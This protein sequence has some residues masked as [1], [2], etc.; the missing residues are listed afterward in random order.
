MSAEEHANLLAALS[1]DLADA[2]ERA[3]QSVVG[4]DARRRVPG[5]GIVWPEGGIVV[6]ADHVIERHDEISLVTSGGHRIGATLIG[7]DPGSDV[8]VL[9]PASAAGRPAELAPAESARV[10]SLALA[11]GRTA[12]GATS[13][14]FGIISAVGGSWRSMRGGAIDSYLRADLTLYPGYSGGPIVDASGRVMGMNSSH[15]AGGQSVALPTAVV[16]GIVDALVAHGRI[17]RAYLGVTS[18]PI[19]VPEA[20]REKAHVD[21]Q[22]GLLLLSVEPGSPADRGGLF[23][24]DVLLAVNDRPVTHPEALQAALGADLV[25]KHVTL[26]LLRG[27]EVRDLSVTPGERE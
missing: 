24:G 9:R 25:G 10:G 2:V 3:S 22:T 1:A 27:G 26:R 18:R 7:R 13:A 8:A 12:S 14:S 19:E 21:Q 4:V 23:L 15:L 5:T 16:R 20:L 17:R 6:T 11:I